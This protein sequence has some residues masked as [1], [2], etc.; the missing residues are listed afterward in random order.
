MSK[1]IK[2]IKREVSDFKASS[3]KKK[4]IKIVGIVVLIAVIVFFVLN[5]KAF[6]LLKDFL[7]V[8]DDVTSVLE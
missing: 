7:K 1:S 4:I 8:A 2:K 5:E 3:G 6:A